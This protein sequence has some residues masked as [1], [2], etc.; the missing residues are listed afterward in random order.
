MRP[1]WHRILGGWLLGGLL[2]GLAILPICDLHFDCGCRWPGLGGYAHCD[3]HTSGPPDC[4]WCA[5]PSIM[6]VSMA[7][8]YAL[9]LAGAIGTARHA[10][11]AFVTLA[12]LAGVLTGALLTGVLTSLLL[13]L[14]VL[15]GLSG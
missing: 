14:P 5:R 12:S 3:I 2:A 1:R 4:P 7:L 9:G 8:S 10:G 13:G 6:V 11:L 15:A